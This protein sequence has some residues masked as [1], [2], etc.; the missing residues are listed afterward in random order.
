MPAADQQLSLPRSIS[1]PPPPITDNLSHS[2]RQTSVISLTITAT[3]NL[4]FSIFCS[5]AQY[6][7]HVCSFTLPVIYCNK[8]LALHFMNVFRR[9]TRM[10]KKPCFDNNR[11]AIQVSDE[12]TQWRETV[13]LNTEQEQLEQIYPHRFTCTFKTLEILISVSV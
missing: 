8:H 3:I 7:Q 9:F 13:L 10:L 4:S 1:F 2:P 6:M 5:S 11:E 12:N